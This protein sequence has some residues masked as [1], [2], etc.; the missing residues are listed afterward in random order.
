MI[1]LPY[2]KVSLFDCVWDRYPLNVDV[3]YGRA[4]C[5]HSSGARVKDK[6]KA[7]FMD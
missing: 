7:V 4:E 5:N 6:I 2:K 3:F 1:N